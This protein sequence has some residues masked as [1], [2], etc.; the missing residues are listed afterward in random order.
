MKKVCLGARDLEVSRLLFGTLTMGP[1]QRGLP[2]EE[3]AALLCYA[4]ERGVNF[5]DTAEYYQTYPYVKEAL[6]KH[7][8]MVVCTKSYAY[9]RDGA[10]RSIDLAQ[11]GIGRERIDI[12]LLH[13]QESEH[14]LRG[15]AEALDYYGELR[16][17]GVIG[18]VGISTHHVAATL[19]AAKWPGVDIVFSLINERGLGI[20]DGGRTDMEQAIA[21]VHENGRSVLAMKALGGGHLIG[22]R[23]R[24]FE[25]ALGLPGVDA[26]AVGMQSEAEID[27]NIAMFEGRE[28][29]EACSQKTRDAQRTLL[30]QAW[31]VGCGRCAE[32]CGQRAICVREGKAVVDAERCVRCGYCAAVCPEFCLKVI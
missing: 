30:V 32:R 29:D 31:C 17:M 4:A 5:V 8:E 11:E 12:F 18:A 23:R 15:H 27:F 7:P 25:Y 13:E 6:K 2:V 16:E 20:V 1:L 24:A 10:K 21:K 28:P 9:D 22:G 3:G 14:T 19:A 26:V